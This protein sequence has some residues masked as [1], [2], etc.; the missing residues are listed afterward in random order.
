MK[1]RLITVTATFDIS[2]LSDNAITPKE[3]VRKMVEKD[4]IDIFE[5][6]EGYDGVKVEVVDIP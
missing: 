4:M 3:E 5:W 2:T 1:K 6:S